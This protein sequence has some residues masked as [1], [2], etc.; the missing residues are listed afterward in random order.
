[1]SSAA[2][3]IFDKDTRGISAEKWQN[4]CRENSIEYSPRTVGGKVYYQGGMGGVEIHFATHKLIF[5]TYW[6]GSMM[7]S[8]ARLVKIAWCRWGGNLSADP[9][10]RKLMCSDSTAKTSKEG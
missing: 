4:F 1:M 8:V 9:E 5:S 2:T 3:I 10:I 7:E 6:G